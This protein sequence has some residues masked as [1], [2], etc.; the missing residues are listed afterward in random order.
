MEIDGLAKDL[1]NYSFI[2]E[3]LNVLVEERKTLTETALDWKK[4][5]NFMEECRRVLTELEEE[6]KGHAEQLRQINQDIN[7]LEDIMKSMQ[8]T[9]NTNKADLCVKAEYLQRTMQMINQLIGNTGDAD[10]LPLTMEEDKNT[11]LKQFLKPLNLPLMP[12][13]IIPGG[14]F[15]PFPIRFP[16]NFP[17]PA[18]MTNHEIT[19]ENDHTW[20]LIPTHHLNHKVTR[21]TSFGQFSI[22]DYGHLGRHLP[23]DTLSILALTWNLNEKQ[24]PILDTMTKFFAFRRNDGLEDIIA[25][26]LQEIRP[27]IR[28]FHEL[29]LERFSSVLIPT[30]HVY[31]SVRFWSQM[32]MIAIKKEHIPYALDFPD[33]QFIPSNAVAKPVRTKGSIGV[34]FKIYQRTIVLVSSHFSHGSISQR[35]ADYNKAVRKFNFRT[36]SLQ[37]KGN[38]SL[39]NAD[40]VVWMGDLN[41]RVPG[42]TSMIPHPNRTVAFGVDIRNYLSKDELLVY[43]S[44]A[45]VFGGFREAEITFPPTYKLD[46]IL[47]FSSDPLVIE[48]FEYDSADCLVDS[49]HRYVYGT[50][51]LLVLKKQYRRGESEQLQRARSTPHIT[52]ELAEKNLGNGIE[53]T[54]YSL[55]LLLNPATSR[56]AGV[57]MQ[58]IDEPEQSKPG[59]AQ[60]G[61]GH[62]NE[63]HQLPPIIVQPTDPY[64]TDSIEK[65]R[66]SLE[67]RRH[68]IPHVTTIS[69]AT[70][71][72]GNDQKQQ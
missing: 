41:F 39:L 5:K 60:S 38:G 10:L 47:C 20:T 56:S 36:I 42:G 30:H 44:R 54:Q 32:M 34:A 28:T 2:R 62:A 58:P 9:A 52:H 25:V 14:L 7:L 46:R 67:N 11:E 1:Y 18:L 24:A 53:S 3:K 15:P 40:A 64:A 68:S 70:R 37:N 29:A 63:G 61:P 51:R 49:D 65:R 23:N 19:Q 45:I 57:V 50:F 43:K 72:K 55:Q 66:K 26:G 31:F 12:P 16:I 13:Q 69:G 21:I 35:W 22:P 6:R 17:P 59:S 4:G 33:A 48:P 8:T 71:P 27:Q